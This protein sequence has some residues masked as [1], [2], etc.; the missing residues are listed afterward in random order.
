MSLRSRD[1]APEHRSGF[2]TEGVAAY[3]W[4]TGKGASLPPFLKDLH[5]GLRRPIN[6]SQG[7]ERPVGPGAS[8]FTRP[9]QIPPSRSRN[10]EAPRVVASLAIKL[11]GIAAGGG[12]NGKRRS[13]PTPLP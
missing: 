7:E 6:R 10:L 11:S 13:A 8:L 12:R 9:A 4:P 2:S 5:A 3:S 1:S